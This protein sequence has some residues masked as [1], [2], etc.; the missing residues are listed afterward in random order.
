M[1]LCLPL[2]VNVSEVSLFFPE[3]MCDYLKKL[4][5]CVVTFFF[6]GGKGTWIYFCLYYSYFVDF[7]KRLLWIPAVREARLNPGPIKHV[8]Y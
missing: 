4:R 8:L 7:L 6:G 3:V 5:W 2:K 1:N